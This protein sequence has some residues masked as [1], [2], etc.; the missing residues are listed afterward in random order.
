MYAKHQGF[1]ALM[2]AIIISAVLM[3]TVV[4]GALSGIY[5]RSNVL[6]AELKSRSRAVADACLEQALLLVTNNP[7]YADTEYQK[8]NDLDACELT[9]TGA[10]PTKTFVIQ[11]SSTNAVTN[12]SATY[13]TGTKALT[14]LA[15]AP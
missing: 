13:D 15:E 1:V 4:A 11:G 8:F 9:I 7:S 12:L 10:A 5:A 3:L 6:D 14:S 2:S